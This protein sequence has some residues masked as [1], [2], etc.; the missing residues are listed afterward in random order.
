MILIHRNST[1]H[2]AF[3]P[4][5]WP[6]IGTHWNS[7]LIHKLPFQFVYYFQKMAIRK[8]NPFRV[9]IK[10]VM[11]NSQKRVAPR[12]FLQWNWQY[13]MYYAEHKFCLILFIWPE[14][15]FNHRY[16]FLSFSPCLSHGYFL[17]DSIVFTSR[18]VFIKLEILFAIFNPSNARNFLC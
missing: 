14:Y 8:Q 18:L 2:L 6:L 7:L 3:S 4:I 16:Q 12:I 17:V 9:Y 5:I 1:N 15:Q 13:I 10:F 11:N